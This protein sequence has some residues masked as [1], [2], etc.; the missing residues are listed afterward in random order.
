[1]TLRQRL[2]VLGIV[3]L[4]V[5]FSVAMKLV[6][7]EGLGFLGEGSLLVGFWASLALV[8]PV[9]VAAWLGFTIRRSGEGNRFLSFGLGWLLLTILSL[10]P[11]LGGLVKVLVTLLGFGALVGWLLQPLMRSSS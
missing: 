2:G 7:W 5:A 6:L 9:V 10:I 4:F 8:A 11:I 1:M 3:I